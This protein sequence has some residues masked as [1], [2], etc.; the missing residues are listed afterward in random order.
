MMVEDKEIL[1]VE[2]GKHL[3]CFSVVII[4]VVYVKTEGICESWV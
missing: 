4:D 3:S 1:E 2:Q